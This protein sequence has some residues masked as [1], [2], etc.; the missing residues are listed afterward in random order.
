MVLGQKGPQDSCWALPP[1]CLPS[2]YLGKHA[3]LVIP[4]LCL[5]RPGVQSQLAAG[6]QC[7]VPTWSIP[8]HVHAEPGH[9]ENGCW[10]HRVRGA[11]RALHCLLSVCQGAQC[12]VLPNT[13]QNNHITGRSTFCNSSCNMKTAP[14]TTHFSVCQIFGEV[15]VAT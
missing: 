2:V 1:V 4:V 15:E 10:V 5:C 7:A 8:T 11:T 13:M 14:P 6:A 12:I 9:T 3:D